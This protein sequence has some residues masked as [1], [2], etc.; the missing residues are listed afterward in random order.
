MAN[1]HDAIDA[2]MGDEVLRAVVRHFLMHGYLGAV[3]ISVSN[4]DQ[5]AEGLAALVDEM[6][7]FDMLTSHTDGL[8]DD[9][10]AASKGERHLVAIL[11][12]A[13]FFEHKINGII[14][15]LARQ[16]GLG[17]QEAFS[18]IRQ[19]TIKQKLK[20]VLEFLGAPPLGKADS[21]N[22]IIGLRNEFVHYRWTP[23]HDKSSNSLVPEISE[24][25]KIV[26]AIN[27][28]EERHVFDDRREA[29]E[30]LMRTAWGPLIQRLS[31]S[32]AT[33]KD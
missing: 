11:L 26:E 32:L 31:R 28:Y 9:A 4:I 14:D 23:R 15:T 5:I 24:C 3:E 13:T 16:K 8:L 2:A 17:A 25:Q 21:I 1:D 30:E 27:N 19:K 29:T 10:L 20:C 7:N 33:H 22:R 12:Y 6:G 18:L